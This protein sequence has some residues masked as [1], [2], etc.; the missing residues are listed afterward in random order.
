MRRPLSPSRGIRVALN[1][2]LRG[3]LRYDSFRCLE[4][5]YIE[6]TDCIFRA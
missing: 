6:Q 4:E 3:G 1:A 5:R 2:Y